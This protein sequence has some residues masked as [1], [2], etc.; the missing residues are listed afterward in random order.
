MRGPDLREVIDSSQQE[1]LRR[2]ASVVTELIGLYLEYSTVQV[3]ERNAK[4]RGYHGSGESSHSA[5]ERTADMNALELTT[6]LFEL[7]AQIKAKLEERDFLRLLLGDS[8][9]TRAGILADDQ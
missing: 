6:T 9:G 2:L 4:V 7:R 8:S 1:L 3:S 5:R